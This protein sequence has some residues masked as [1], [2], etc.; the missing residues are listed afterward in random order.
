MVGCR[1]RAPAISSRLVYRGALLRRAA[2]HARRAPKTF[3]GA[4]EPCRGQSSGTSPGCGSWSPIWRPPRE[5]RRQ[6]VVARAKRSCP[7]PQLQGFSAPELRGD[8]QAR[9]LLR[10]D[11]SLASQPSPSVRYGSYFLLVRRTEE[12]RTDCRGPP[13][14]I[15]V[16]SAR[17]GSSGERESDNTFPW[18][19]VSR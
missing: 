18:G 5:G 13:P 15:R 16:A 19:S 4:T 3:R 6:H 11:P 1:P 9:C 8:P 10:T 12:V 7:L 17:V 2:D 14:T